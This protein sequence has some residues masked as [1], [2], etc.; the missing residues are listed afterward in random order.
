MSHNQ[1]QVKGKE[2]GQRSCRNPRRPA[3]L[4]RV[5]GCRPNDL[6]ARL[7]RSP[8]GSPSRCK[9]A[10]VKPEAQ[11]TFSDSFLSSTSGPHSTWFFTH[12]NSRAKWGQVFYLWIQS[13][14][15]ALRSGLCQTRPTTSQSVSLQRTVGA[16]DGRLWAMGWGQSGKELG[17]DLVIETSIVLEGVTVVVPAVTEVEE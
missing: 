15:L 12:H 16:E 1:F 13:W 14:N 2:E 3:N 11:S 6:Q 7:P 9:M 10:P 5:H 4:P 17:C 8:Q